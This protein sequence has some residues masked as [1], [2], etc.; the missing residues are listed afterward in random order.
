MRLLPE[1]ME[2]LNV[3]VVGAG[4][5]QQLFGPQDRFLTHIETELNI[6]VIV[7]NGDVSIH[8][9]AK[10]IQTA[11][12]L[13]RVLLRL[14]RRGYQV[15]ERDVLYALQ[16]AQEDL[17][18]ELIELYEEEITTNYKGKPIRVKTL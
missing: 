4:E 12:A 14:I 10:R 7:R 5:A 8:G 1:Q 15:S 6:Q 2:Q 13:F 9:S 16:L 3:P 18:D 17:V 11:D